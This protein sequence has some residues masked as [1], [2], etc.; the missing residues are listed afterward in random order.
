[1]LHQ[2]IIDILYLKSW[3]KKGKGKYILENVKIGKKPI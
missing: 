2:K 3:M 1:M